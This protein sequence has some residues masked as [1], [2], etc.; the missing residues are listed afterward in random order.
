VTDKLPKGLKFTSASGD[1]TYNSTTGIWTIGDLENGGT[2]V[3]NIIAQATAANTKVTN[4][5]AI[6]GNNY[7]QKSSNNKADAIVKIGPAADL[8]VKISV[9]NAHPKYKQKVTFTIT[10]YNYGP[11]GAK[12]VTVTLKMPK[13][14]KYVSKDR[15]INYNPKTGV[16][17]IG[18]LK[19]GSKIVLHVVEQAIVSNVKLTTTASIKGTAIMK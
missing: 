6:K 1:G 8:A 2:A 9:S 16:W 11:M 17:T 7:D 15:N 18:N 5:A 19:S 12:G 3:L 13:G 14:F 4:T 10:A